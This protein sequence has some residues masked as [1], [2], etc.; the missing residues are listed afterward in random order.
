MWKLVRQGASIM[1][2]IF[3]M[4]HSPMK[5]QKR[6][7]SNQYL[8]WLL[9]NLVSMMTGP[10][11]TIQLCSTISTVDWLN[12]FQYFFFFQENPN[13]YNKTEWDRKKIVVIV[14]IMEDKKKCTHSF[15]EN[16][17]KI[18]VEGQNPRLKRKRE[19]NKKWTKKK[20]KKKITT[21]C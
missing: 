3:K 4:T 10:C 8:L 15:I 12:C 21:T 5:I 6:H 16:E 17:R 18:N 19:F 14:I 20:K 7:F 2:S 11:N 1:I 9:K 13:V